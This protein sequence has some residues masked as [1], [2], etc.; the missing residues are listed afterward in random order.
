MTQLREH[1]CLYA[2]FDTSMDADLSRGARRA[3]SNADVVR[4]DAGGG[5]HGGALVFS[6]ADHACAEDE[7]T[8]P[9]AGNFPYSADS[10]SGTISLWLSGDP[11]ADLSDV[12]PVDPF[13]ISRHPADGSFYLDL[14]RPHD[15]RYGAP[16]KLRFG[17]YGD[18]PEQSRFSGGQLIV[19]GELGWRHGEWH[20]VVATWRNANSGRQDGGAA[21]YIDGV[22]RGWMAGYRHH[23]TW[24]VDELTIGI[25]Q[26]YCGAIDELLIL[27]RD[28][29]AREVAELHQLPGPLRDE[30]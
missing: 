15:D 13:H 1:I 16:R 10:F 27:D 2:S 3:R 18:S 7:L 9:A 12:V 22:R 30:L 24:N 25:G 28:L 19:V 26:R 6:A 23:L 21:V 29:T 8:Y 5:R 17:L 4:R 11:D 14:T 20:H